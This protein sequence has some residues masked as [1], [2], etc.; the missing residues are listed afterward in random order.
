MTTVA[1]LVNG[2]PIQ[3]HGP[4][5]RAFAG[6]LQGVSQDRDLCTGSR[7]SSGRRCG[8]WRRSCEQRPE[9]CYVFDMAYSGVVARP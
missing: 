1:F 6:H 7:G 2:E 8:S 9:V 5:R 3:R 4:A